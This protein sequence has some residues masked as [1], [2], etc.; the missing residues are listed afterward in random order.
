[1][2]PRE[3]E[4][5]RALRKFITRALR[6]TIECGFWRVGMFWCS[7]PLYSPYSFFKTPK[8]KARRFTPPEAVPRAGDV[9]FADGGGREVRLSVADPVATARRF[10]EGTNVGGCAKAGGSAGGARAVPQNGQD[11]RP[12]SGRVPAK[13][14]NFVREWVHVPCWDDRARARSP[15]LSF[16]NALDLGHFLKSPSRAKL[17]K[18]RWGGHRPKWA[19]R[20]APFCRRP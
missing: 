8:T 18:F 2:I 17:Q 20:P 5:E 4:R 10:G 3:R 15:R 13:C 12:L 7:C 9:R 16:Q 14:V 11:P 1:M 19:C 6:V